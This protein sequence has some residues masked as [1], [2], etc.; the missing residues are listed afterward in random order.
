MSKHQNIL[1]YLEQNGWLEQLNCHPP[2]HISFLA[3][4]EYNENWLITARAL[5]NTAGNATQQTDRQYVFRINH[6]SQLGLGG[7]QIA[8]EYAVL[9]AIKY[10]NATPIPYFYD[11]SAGE[12][13]AALGH[14][15]LL[16][17]YLNGTPLEYAQDVDCAAKIFASIHSQPVPQAVQHGET[18]FIH[19]L[20][21][22][23]DIVE[24]SYSML[25]RFADH[26][27]KDVRIALERYARTIEDVGRNYK[28]T[29]ATEPQMLV[30]TEVNSGN[31]IIDRA[32]GTH[33]LVDWEKAVVS[34]RF[35]DLAHFFAP[36]TTLWKTDFIAITE[37]KKD[38]LSRYREYARLQ[39]PVEE[40]FTLATVL[41]RTIVLRGLSW[42]Y[43][44]W[45]EYTQQERAIKNN[46]TFTTMERYLD[47]IE[48]FLQ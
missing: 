38:F 3:A 22:V 10:S 2:H 31:F 16:M 41:E 27:K 44:A 39:Q 48:W 30:N 11:E 7:K 1:R 19:Q 34:C 26:P 9:D 47:S 36:V 8:Y 21:P 40:L 42:C 17:E 37:Y 33:F 28:S 12:Y 35:Q 15:V 24:E 43:M 45:Y 6:G 18:P 29:F 25:S 13:D 46:D 5:P 32:A 14:G 4:G 23:A 20:D